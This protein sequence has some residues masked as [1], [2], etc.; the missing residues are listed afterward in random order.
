MSEDTRKL[1]EKMSELVQGQHFAS[2]GMFVFDNF[3]AI[4]AALQSADQEPELLPCPFCG[5][6]P[7]E[8]DVVALTEPNERGKALFKVECDGCAVMTT[9]YHVRGQAIKAWN[10][11]VKP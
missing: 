10:T 7:A 2:L 11:R 1:I 5:D 6:T 3:K 9:W 8:V 4:L